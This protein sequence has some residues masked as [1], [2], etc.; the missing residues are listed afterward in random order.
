METALLVFLGLVVAPLAGGLIGGADR[1]L[2]AR[3][4]SRV[5]PPL[6]QPFFD[7]A[8]LWGKETSVA[9]VWQGFCTIMYVTAAATSVVLFFLQSDLLLIFFVQVVGAVFLVIGALARI[10]H[11]GVD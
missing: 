1:I 2:T 7:A 10:I 6:L 4:Q 8:K 3:F 9:N 5:G 11:E